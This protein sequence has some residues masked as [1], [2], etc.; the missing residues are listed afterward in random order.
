MPYC[1]ECHRSRDEDALSCPADGCYYRVCCCPRC[2]AEAAPWEAW[3]IACGASLE[4]VSREGVVLPLRRA[5]WGSRTLAVIVD[6]VC[7]SYVVSGL[8]G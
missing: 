3:C 2:D 5:S 6:V 4:A 1:P 8:P 7:L